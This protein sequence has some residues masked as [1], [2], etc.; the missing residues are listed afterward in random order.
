MLKKSQIQTLILC[1]DREFKQRATLF[2]NNSGI[3][4]EK[5][6]ADSF[7]T[8]LELL[9]SNPKIKNLVVQGDFFTE[10]LDQKLEALKKILANELM[11]AL[12][13]FSEDK[14]EQYKKEYNIHNMLVEKVPFA[15]SHFNTA[16]YNRGSE[17]S[18][19]SQAASGLSAFGITAPIKS[20]PNAQNASSTKKPKPN[21]SALE[22]SSHVKQTIE[23]LNI[24]IKNR[25]DLERVRSIG[26]VFNGF[27]GAFAYF[28]GKSGFTELHKLAKIED[29]VSRMYPEDGENQ[30]ISAEH[31]ELMLDAAKASFKILQLL[32]E[33]KVVPEELTQES[34]ALWATFEKL[35]G[36]DSD[37]LDQDA[38]DSLLD[39]T[40][41]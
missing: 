17:G 5:F 25:K 6:S 19:K 21:L 18:G 38:I 15:Q 28:K 2:L 41:T 39:D 32:R 23:Y 26:Q 14:Y 13:Y 29:L 37:L 30:E 12:I 16:F 34:E 40:S 33:N 4:T 27:I 11:Y 9:A 7:E 36:K 8:G 1:K 22:A 35:G 3:H 10:L 31:C 20:S 24:I